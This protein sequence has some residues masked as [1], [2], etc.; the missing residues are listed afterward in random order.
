MGIEGPHPGIYIP[1]NISLSPT[2]QLD[3]SMQTVSPVRI[4]YDG[5]VSE[6]DEVHNEPPAHIDVRIVYGRLPPDR[7]Q[8]IPHSRL[9]LIP[10]SQS[11]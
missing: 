4:E 1:R 5:S 2:D 11:P 3:G 10:R 7:C 9:A 6:T 8:V